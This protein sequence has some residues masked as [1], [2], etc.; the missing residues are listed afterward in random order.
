MAENRFREGL[1][2]RINVNQIQIPPLR[3]HRED[4]EVLATYFLR[5]HAQASGRAMAFSP[6]ALEILKRYRWPG[7][8]RELKNAVEHAFLLSPGEEIRPEALPED[9]LARDGAP[10][11]QAGFPASHPAPPSGGGLLLSLDLTMDEVERRFILALYEKAKGN[12]TLAAKMLGIGL[13][14]LYRKLVKYG[15]MKAT[16]EDA[17]LEQKEA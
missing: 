9:V 1:Y 15:V 14:T 12:K 6:P 5:Q 3:E 7:N 2:F 4:I 16:E 17:G 11:P 8:V 13:K 10:S